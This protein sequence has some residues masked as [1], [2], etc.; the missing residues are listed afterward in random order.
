MSATLS[1]CSMERASE[2]CR[3]SS[4][5]GTL[6][7]N[8]CQRWSVIRRN[9]AL[10]SAPSSRNT[11]KTTLPLAPSLLVMNLGRLG[12]TL[13]LSSSRLS[14]RLQHQRDR[15]KYN[16]R[17]ITKQHFLTMK[18]TCIR[19]LYQQDRQWMENYIATFWGDWGKISGANVQTRSVTTHGSR[20]MTTLRVPCRSLYGG[21]SLPVM[22]SHP[23]TT[24]HRT[25]FI[26]TPED[27]T[28]VEGTRL[29]HH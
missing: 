4:T 22:R 14:G 15:R 21:F 28:E 12:T 18:A 10:L 29:W 11:A 23:P 9:T 17:A 24:R 6:Q 7:Q 13:R 26:L 16:F 2:F 5:W 1:N 19:N 3:I 20:I 8:L 25:W 27:E